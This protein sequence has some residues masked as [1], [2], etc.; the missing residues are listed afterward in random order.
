MAALDC[1]Q[2]RVLLTRPEGRNGALQSALQSA[3]AD[4]TVAPLLA[5]V[6]LE[7]LDATAQQRCRQRILDLDHYS[8][9][10]FISVNAVE[11]GCELI[12]TY[13]PQWPMGLE[14]F[15]IG[16]ATARALQARGLPVSE[17][18]E[19]AM[20]SEA[21]L[22][23]AA[24]QHIDQQ[25]ILI[26]RGLGGR[27]TLAETLRQRGARVDYAECYGRAATAISGGEL[28]A[29]LIQHQINTVVLN[30]GETLARF[31]ALTTAQQRQGFAAIVPSAR[32]A[33][34]AATA[35]FGDTEQAAN[36]GQSATLAALEDL[37][38]RWPQ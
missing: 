5:I 15:A 1:R 10:I 13:W 28:A 34:L 24:L 19:G 17:A 6:P 25:R 20:N 2:L 30:S 9:V 18:G 3:G 14:L 11:Q 33:E 21:L 29:L 37:A 31:V 36:A 8:I 22:A 35:S 23:L 12:D 38:Q 32:V 26:V 27:E 4:V 7:S 16:E